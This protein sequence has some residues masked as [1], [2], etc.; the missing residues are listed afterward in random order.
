V[1][2]GKEYR[3]EIVTESMSSCPPFIFL[4]S[5]I[6]ADG[7]CSHKIKRRLLLER[8]TL[9]NIDSILKSREPMK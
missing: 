5:Q 3:L 9:I 8:K 6:T 1:F 4:G 7:D 2:N